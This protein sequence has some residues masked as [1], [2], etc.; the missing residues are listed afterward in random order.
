M[1]FI[2]PQVLALLSPLLLLAEGGG[3]LLTKSK[4]RNHAI[5]EKEGA[6]CRPLL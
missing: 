5:L 6:K 3:R 2:F 4:A 1:T